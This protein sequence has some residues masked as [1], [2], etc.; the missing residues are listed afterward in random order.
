MSTSTEVTTIR[1][2]SHCISAACTASW[3]P[4]AAAV[5]LGAN[6]IRLRLLPKVGM[7]TRSPG[8]REQHLLDEVTDVVRVVRDGGAAIAANPEGKVDVDRHCALTLVWATRP[9][10]GVPGA[11]HTAWLSSNSNG[12]PCDVTSRRADDPVRGDAGRIGVPVRRT[13]R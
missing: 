6:N 3:S 1:S 2:P 10:S 13:L 11:T 5:L 7:L 12:C 8:H 4:G 9:C